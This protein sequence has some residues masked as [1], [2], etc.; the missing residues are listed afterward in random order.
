MNSTYF[1]CKTDNCEGNK[2]IVVYGEA[3]PETPSCR[4]CSNPY[5]VSIE[6][7]ELNLWG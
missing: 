5:I 2:Y 3:I 4:Y 1:Y 6:E 7:E